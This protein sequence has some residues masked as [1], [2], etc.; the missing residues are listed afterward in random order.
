[1][2]FFELLRKFPTE[3]KAIKHFISIRYE[4]VTCPHCGSHKVYRR[5]DQPKLFACKEC[6]NSFSIFKGTI[7]EKSCTD[8]RT[9]FY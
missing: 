7:F 4:V 2:N 5:K 9:W 6:N 3:E 8:I 1:M